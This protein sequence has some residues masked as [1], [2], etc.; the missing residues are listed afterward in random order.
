MRLGQLIDLPKIID[1]RGN[2]T[3]VEGYGSIPFD[4]RRAYWVYVREVLD[5]VEGT[6]IAGFANYWWLSAGRLP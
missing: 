5:A 3:V 1:P 6:L 4:I 2:L